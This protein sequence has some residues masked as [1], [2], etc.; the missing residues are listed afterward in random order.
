M[1]KYLRP[2]IEVTTVG[3]ENYLLAGSGFGVSSQDFTKKRHQEFDVDTKKFAP[4]E[5]KDA[6]IMRL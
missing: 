1:K 6:D 2:S 3:V 5:F 4:K